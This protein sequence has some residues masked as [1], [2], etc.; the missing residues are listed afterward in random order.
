[1]EGEGRNLMASTCRDELE[2]GDRIEVDVDAHRVR[3]QL[4]QLVNAIPHPRI[5]EHD[6][7]TDETWCEHWHSPILLLLSRPY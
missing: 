4:F 3:R 5:S 2:R 1:M 6:I 7:A